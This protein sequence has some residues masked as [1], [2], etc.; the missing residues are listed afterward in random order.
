[1]RVRRKHKM[2]YR[3][4]PATGKIE[5]RPTNQIGEGGNF[6]A[7]KKDVQGFSRTLQ[8][9]ATA[10]SRI[11]LVEKR[12]PAKNFVCFKAKPTIGNSRSEL[13]QTHNFEFGQRVKINIEFKIKARRLDSLNGYILQFWQPVISPIAGVRV[14]NG[15]L[16]VVTRSAGGVASMWLTSDWQG[17][18][19]IFT[20]GNQ[21][22]F[23]IS[24]DL[25]GSVRGKIDGGSQASQA[26][27]DTFRAKFGW[28]GA[29]EQDVQVR[30]REF[31]LERL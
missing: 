4:D 17:L 18:E 8:G 29:T 5:G 6:I 30:F 16:E 23:S 31:R 20:A 15:R 12:N 13:A 26:V 19:M 9:K 25:N 21:G 24:G 7:R 11:E 10:G 22:E 14:Q 1:M 27:A 28:Y 3:M 2:F